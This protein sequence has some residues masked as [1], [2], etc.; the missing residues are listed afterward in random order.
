MNRP[1][2]RAM[3]ALTLPAL[4]W[5]LVV[6][7]RYPT[8]MRAAASRRSSL[9]PSSRIHVLCGRCI[10]CAASAVFTTRC[11]GSPAQQMNTSVSG[12]SIS[13]MT[14]ARRITA[15]SSASGMSERYPTRLD[16]MPIVCRTTIDSAISVRIQRIGTFSWERS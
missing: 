8:P 7:R 16:Q 15:S 14:R 11:S 1:E 6:R 10:S 13:A 2:V 9:R 5:A 3:A 4:A 12:V